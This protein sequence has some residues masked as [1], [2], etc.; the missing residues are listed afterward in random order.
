M[1][2]DSKKVCS[3]ST[4]FS[5]AIAS[6]HLA[7]EN[8]VHSRQTSQPRLEWV[9]VETRDA[10]ERQVC[11]CWKTLSPE[12]GG[13]R[14]PRKGNNEPKGKDSARRPHVAPELQNR[15]QKPNP[16]RSQ[17]DQDQEESL[18]LC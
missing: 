12:T 10:H 1:P 8:Q 13:G 14:A 9:S 15:G 7:A 5:P 3:W 11:T 6:R 17:S 18:S 16:Q 2:K 4:R